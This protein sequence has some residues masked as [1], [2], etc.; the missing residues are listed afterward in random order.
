MS[1]PVRPERGGR[2]TW[3]SLFD[4]Y[5]GDLALRAAGVGTVLASGWFVASRWRARSRPG[6]DP[7][8]LRHGGRVAVGAVVA[9]AVLTHER[10]L[11]VWRLVGLVAIVATAVAVPAGRRPD[12]RIVGV[13]TLVSLVGVWAAVPDTEP[14][15]IAAA[16]LGVGVITGTTQGGWRADRVAAIALVSITAWIGARGRIE[17][18]GGLACLGLLVTLPPARRE[19]GSV[20]VTVALH[21]VLV[22]IAARLLTRASPG[23]AVAGAA[24]VALAGAGY[25]ASFRRP[26]AHSSEA[27]E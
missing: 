2:L 23:W 12:R 16:V 9:A 1:R 10:Y 25:A 11:T 5:H 6:S 4:R 7:V 20:V 27:A 8:R 24:A 22:G 26:P 19:R 21:L 15:L 18:I 13:L 17:A 14:A 3:T